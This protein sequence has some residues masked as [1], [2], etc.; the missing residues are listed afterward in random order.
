[1]L[2]MDVY[3]EVVIEVGGVSGIWPGSYGMHDLIF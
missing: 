3:I 1:M 2:E